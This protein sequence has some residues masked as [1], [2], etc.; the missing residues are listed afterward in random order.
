MQIYKIKHQFPL[1][2]SHKDDKH[3]FPNLRGQQPKLKV[4]KWQKII[5]PLKPRWISSPPLKP[6]QIK[7]S[8]KLNK[9]RRPPWSREHKILSSELWHPGSR[10]NRIDRI[11]ILPRY[12]FFS[13]TPQQRTP[14]LSVFDPEQFQDGWLKDQRRRPEGGKWEPIKIPR[15]NS[16]YIPKSTRRP[17][18]INSTLLSSN[19]VKTAQL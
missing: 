1:K 15:G 7:S 12:T 16:V 14:G 19:S 10:L 9:W 8:A 4:Y 11:I 13:R 2:S 5:L 6:R 18:K 3:Q 17:Y